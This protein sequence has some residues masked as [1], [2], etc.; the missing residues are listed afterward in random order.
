[1]HK[2]E[3]NSLLMKFGAYLTNVP[4]WKSS[5]R[6]YDLIFAISNKTKQDLI[7]NGFD[8]DK[9]IVSYIGIDDEYFQPMKPAERPIEDDYIFAIGTEQERKN[10]KGIIEAF[11]II[12]IKYP[13]L[14]LLK[15]GY[16]VLDEY[17]MNT[18][19]LINEINPLLKRDIVF[20]NQRL[21]IEEIKKLYVHS[22]LLLFP[23][24]KEGFGLPIIEAQA[25]GT[26]VITRNKEP[27][28]ELIPYKELL[29]DAY[30]S[31][32]IA[33]KCCRILEND[34]YRKKIIEDGKAFAARFTWDKTAK[35]NKAI[36][37][38]DLFYLDMYKEEFNSLLMKF[39]AYVTYVPLW[40]SSLKKYDL[41]FAISNKT[42][43]D[44]IA[45]GFNADKIIVTYVGIDDEYFQ[46]MKPYE[47]PI[48]DDYIFVIGTEQGR[49][50]MKGILE[51]F[52]IIKLK[53][54]KLKLLKAGYGVLG[55]Y[56]KNTLNLIKTIDPTLKEDIVFL[57]RKLTLDEVKSCYSFSKLL[58]FPSLKEGFGAPIIEA[59]AIGTPVITTNEGPMSELVPYQELLID[60][61]NSNDIAE[62]C[63]RI[64]EN[65]K[66]RM[67]IIEDGKKFASKFTWSRTSEIIYNGLLQSKK[68]NS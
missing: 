29:V 46:P 43:Q 21:T 6:R 58:L 63:C 2:Y 34:K 36:M 17:R 41:I 38:H 25:I 14:K 55:E 23:S 27:M 5:L 16:G 62:K 66:Y 13:K 44:L 68:D 40:K 3:F 65:E 54:P 28:S 30:D 52:R 35:G 24:L 48:E 64:L 11:S 31:N 7:A 33:E 10:M 45:N 67:K 9:I 22:K 57:D 18:L 49:K 56:R 4:F 61:Y 39:G 53:Y 51:A 20:F 1:M 15:A 50:N 60:A 47:R 12:K 19:K 42:K 8:S 26:P 32:D 59:Q 37:V